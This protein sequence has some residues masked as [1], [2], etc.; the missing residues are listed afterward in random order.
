MSHPSV[1]LAFIQQ[2]RVALCEYA[3]KGLAENGRGMVWFRKLTLDWEA[4]MEDA[5]YLSEDVL[6]VSPRME[7]HMRECDYESGFLIYI[8]WDGTPHANQF[9]IWRIRYDGMDDELIEDD[10]MRRAQLTPNL[11]RDAWQ[12]ILSDRIREFARLAKIGMHETGSQGMFVVCVGGGFEFIPEHVV[13]GKSGFV[14]SVAER[15]VATY[16]MRRQFVF[17]RTYEDAWIVEIP[18]GLQ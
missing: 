11:P 2:N 18:E 3:R 5:D 10:M 6:A 17:A 13:G 7:F 4:D 9:N 1:Q 14:G 16:D 12:A 15:L 8:G